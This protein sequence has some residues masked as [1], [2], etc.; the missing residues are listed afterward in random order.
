[1]SESLPDIPDLCWPVDWSCYGGPGD[2]ELLAPD[3]K[4]KAEAL[5]VTSLR[6]LT[7]GQVGG[8][9]ITIRPCANACIPNRFAASDRFE[10]M[11][12]HIF[13]GVWVNSCGCRDRQSC[14]CTLL[15]EVLLPPPVG[16]VTQVKEDG[17]ALDPDAYRVDDGN[18]LVRLDGG[19]WM[20][21]QDMSEPDSQEG[22]FSVTY[23]NALPVDG[24]AS[25]VAGLLAAEFLKM[26]QGQDCVLPRNVVGYTRQGVTVELNAG[27][28]P[29]NRTGIEAV[30]AWLMRFNPYK[31]SAPA[32]VYSPDADSPRRTTW[33]YS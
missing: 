3:L 4:A 20:A 27:V 15:S 25:Y 23:L 21:C 31:A 16:E 1:M 11:T 12:P 26:C 30:D 7:L 18:R 14:S 29:N 10:W 5:A 17:V 28:F 22:T 19:Q 2:V 13:D 8:C 6:A 32:I 33:S 9:P 24:L